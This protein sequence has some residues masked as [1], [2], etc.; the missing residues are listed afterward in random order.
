MGKAIPVLGKLTVQIRD[1]IT[2]HK[3]ASMMFKTWFGDHLA[4]YIHAEPSYC[5]L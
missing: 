2:R 3:K 5:T 1:R 4:R